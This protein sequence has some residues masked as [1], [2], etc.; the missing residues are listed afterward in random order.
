MWKYIAYQRCNNLASACILKPVGSLH[1]KRYLQSTL[2]IDW[3]QIVRSSHLLLSDSRNYL[4]A[5][6]C[7]SEPVCLYEWFNIALCYWC[8]LSAEK[9]ENC[10]AQKEIWSVSCFSKKICTCCLILFNKV[11][12]RLWIIQRYLLTLQQF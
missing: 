4:E 2:Y 5:R 1:F 10:K 9:N 8:R 6:M 7:R 11:L 3:S 12:K